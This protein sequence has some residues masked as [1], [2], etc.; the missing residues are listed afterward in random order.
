MLSVIRHR[1]ENSARTNSKRFAKI[2]RT[3]VPTRVFT[4]RSSLSR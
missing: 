3:T 4:T 1:A 2:V